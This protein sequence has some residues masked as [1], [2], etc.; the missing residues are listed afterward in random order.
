MWREV[1]II[2]VFTVGIDVRLEHRS[3]IRKLR[4]LNR[5]K[6]D[7]TAGMVAMMEVHLSLELEVE[8]VGLGELE[9]ISNIGPDRD[10]DWDDRVKSWYR[11]FKDAP[12]VV[13][14][15]VRLVANGC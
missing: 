10:L 8:K 14:T 11:E 5:L 3:H 9:D 1:I 12:K 4:I 15:I 6:E 13:V 7:A 2:K